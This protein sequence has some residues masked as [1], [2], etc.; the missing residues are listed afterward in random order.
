MRIQG[1]FISN[2]S[3]GIPESVVRRTFLPVCA[4][5]LL[6]ISAGMSQITSDALGMHNLAPGGTSP[7][8]ASGDR[9]CGFCHV[10]H[11]GV[12]TVAPLWNQT[13][14]K[15]AYTPYNSST[16][17]EQGNTQ[18]PLGKSTSLCLSCHDGTVAV[19]ETIVAGKTSM[20]GAMFPEDVLGTNLTSSHPVSLQLPLK[21]SADLVSSLAGSGLTADP[22]H[23]KLI[24]KNV[25]CNSCHNPHVQNNDRLSPNFLVRES[26][27]GSLCLACHD[28]TRTMTGRINPLAGWTGSSHATATNQ[29]AALAHVG[30]YGTVAQNACLSCHMPHDAAPGTPRLLRAAS[31]A[32]PTLDK[33]TQD[34]VTCHAGGSNL[35]P[36]APN[37]AAEF[38]KTGHPYTAGSSLH[39]AAET[40][41]LNNSRHSACVD[42]HNP[43]ATS[44]VSLFSAPPAIRV[45]QAGVSG[46]SAD[47]TTTLTPAVN[48]YESCLRCHGTSAGKQ[49]LAA[50]GYS[51]IRAVSAGDPLNIIPQF[52]TNVSSGHP[53]MHDRNSPLPQPSL[54]VNMLNLDGSTPSRLMG[55]RIM[56]TDCHNSDDNREFGG[57]GPNGPHGS[58]WTHILERRYEFSQVAAGAQAGT[59][60]QNLFPNPDQ[61]VNGPYAL[62]GK[63]H[64]LGNILSVGSSFS[65]HAGHINAGYSCSV[66]HTSH[67]MGAIS[68]SISGER[69][70]NFDVNVVLQNG[71]SL[72]SYNRVASTCTLTCHGFSHNANGT[73][74]KAP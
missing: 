69:M 21:D 54:R 25:E 51:P 5:I 73:V 42:C 3:K 7:V 67:G 50:F 37:I 36:A 35:S 63:C 47:G 48:Q 15:A 18:P 60:I 31:P 4:L 39:D 11:S 27:N 65:K 56:C 70:V 49:I 28:T 23:V 14:S 20:T 26:S 17:H 46:I 40:A 10:P 45:S 44:P 16:Y 68:A 71:S 6:T 12:P 74:A 59:L 24:N 64:D 62:C 66:C 53:V 30:G 22:A 43:H 33:S 57:A 72:I 38:G 55:V 34:C 2:T 8:K 32:A 58:R 29:T 19:G 41:V 13:L 52:S 9:G 1:D 61:S